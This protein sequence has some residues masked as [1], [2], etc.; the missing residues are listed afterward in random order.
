MLEVLSVRHILKIVLPVALS[1]IAFSATLAQNQL[2]QGDPPVAALISISTPDD[3]GVV[4][5]TGAAGA[6]FPSAQVAIRNLYTEQVVYVQ[7]G[8]TGAFNARI[9]GPGNTP[10]LINP[11]VSIPFETRGRPGSLPGGPGTIIYAAF[12]EA[13]AVTPAPVTQLV[14]D[15]VLDDWNVYSQANEFVLRNRDSLYLALAADQIPAQYAALRINFTVNGTA[16]TLALDPRLLQTATLARVSPNAANLGT[17]A[18]AAA[19]DE[20]IEVR[21]PLAFIQA[22]VRA[23]L[24]NKIEFVDAAGAEIATYFPEGELP[25]VDEIDGI[26]YHD[27]LLAGAEVTRF[28]VSGAL[29]QGAAM[30]TARGRANKLNFA[31]GETLVMEMDFT[32]NVPDLAPSLVGLRFIGQIRLQPVTDGTG[33]QA[34]GGL[35]SSSGWSSLLTPSDLAIDNVRA[36][37]PLGEASVVPQAVIRRGD[38]VI[39]GLRYD[40]ALPEDLP[41]GLYTPTFQGWAQ[42]GDGDPIRWE[43]NGLFGTGTGLSRVPLTRLPI[44]LNIGRLANARLAWALFYSQPSEGSRGLLPVEDHGR[45]ALSNRVRYNSPTY[46]LP[47]G[48]YPI[49]PYLLNQLANAYDTSSVPLVPLLAPGGRLDAQITLPDGTLDQVGAA[50]IVQNRVSGGPDERS[51]FGASVP[52][53]VFRLT[54]LAPSFIAYPFTQYGDYHI[55]LTGSV[56]DVWGNRY[57]GGGLYHLLVAEQLKLVP[58]VLP[59]TPFEVGNVFYPAIHISPGVPADVRVTLRVYPLDGAAPVEVVFDGRADPYGYFDPRQIF[60]FDVPG[61]YIVDYEARYT[62]AQGRLWAGSLRGASVIAK[63]ESALVAR[64]RRGIVGAA[65][66]Q[67]WFT[68][69]QYPLGGVSN[70]TLYLPYHSG[71][72]LWIPDA[73]QWG[74]RP[75]MDV[76]DVGGS[77]EDWLLG[78]LPDYIGRDGLPIRRLVVEDALPLLSVIAGPQGLYNAA[79]LPDLVV[80]QAYAYI[81][82]VRPAVSVSQWV[83]GGDDEGF[84]VG[85]NTQDPYNGQIGVGVNG[86]RPGDFSFVFGGVIV[87]NTEAGIHDSAIY[88]ALAVTTAADDSRRA[89]VYPPYRGEA[90]GPDGGPLFNL[91]G[92]EVNMFFHPT[93]AQPGQVFFSGEFLSIA[94]QAAPTLASDVAVK[95]TSPSGK[96][97]RFEGRANKIGYFYDP[98]HDIVLNEIGVWSVQITVTHR[99]MT[100]AGQVEAPFPTGGVLGASENTFPVYVVPQGAPLLAVDGAL[101]PDRAIRPASPVNFNFALPTGWTNISAYYTVTMPGYILESG[102][103]R[104]A[105]RTV[106]YQYSPVVLARVFPNL[107]ADGRGVGAAASDEVTLTFVLTGQDENGRFLARSRTFTIRHDR[108]ITAETP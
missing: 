46:I 107:E 108:M 88:A 57:E 22:E 105:A 98:Q 70:A 54:T 76:Q 75:T 92:G 48:T 33:M 77:Y 82:A 63:P 3:A 74:V 17:V 5:I 38:Q 34:S 53:D 24:V 62:D 25:F 40:I 6:V 19:Q 68:T 20:G 39:F 2:R 106:A 13:R 7:A 104:V 28:S 101:V 4:T 16:Y 71:D 41:P 60:T 1:L 94:G 12:P 29:A 9:Y 32:M 61:E 35:N 73:A 93:G 44:V 31:P 79:L 51:L 84:A 43:D 14:I 10:F 26:V 87:R 42:V 45:V 89:Q 59:G 65:R 55:R 56:E 80:S 67:A 103:L 15:G 86:D 64:G 78:T 102:T 52:V 90:G 37:F 81:S 100:S 27:T 18:A 83:Q 21:V 85:W 97:Y 66:G 47:P 72:V 36:D 49:E 95:V 8:I 58:A 99:G 11:T 69:R 96:V 91:R 23:A 50:P 30:W